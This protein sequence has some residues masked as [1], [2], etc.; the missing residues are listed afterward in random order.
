MTRKIS[1]KF[2]GKLSL[3]IVL[4]VAKNQGFTLILENTI[5]EKGQGESN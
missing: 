3:A 2:L 5:S 1:I 4:K